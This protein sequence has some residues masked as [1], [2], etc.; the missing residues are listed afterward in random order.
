MLIGSSLPGTA[1]PAEETGYY[2]DIPVVVS[3]TRLA[4][5]VDDTPVAVTVIDRELIQAAGVVELADILRL[6]PGF[7]VAHTSGNLFT[8][9]AHGTGA[10]WF[11]R[12]QVLVDGQSRYHTG[13]SGLDWAN[14][15]IS[16]A[17]VER[18]EVVRGANTPTYGAN[19]IMG[20]VNIITRQPFQDRGLFLQTTVG[21]QDRID[22]V[23]RHAGNL[24]GM[25]YRLTLEHR[26]NRGFDEVDDDT[27]LNQASFRG[28]VN[29]TPRDELDI[30]L[31]YVES[32]LGLQLHFD[33]PLD[34]R[35]VQTDYQF[36]RWT[37]AAGTD[38][39]FYLQFT[40]DHYRTREDTRINL[41]QFSDWVG[42]PPSLVAFALPRL[43][44][45]PLSFNNF[46]G[47]S[48]RYELEF[49][50]FLKPLETF[51][52]IW[53][54]AYR[55]DE[56]RNDQTGRDRLSAESAR[57][58][59]NLEWRPGERWVTN[60]GAMLEHSTLSDA[61]AFSPRLGINYR[62]ADD[63]T[64]RASLTR[65]HKFPSLLEE[66]W[67]NYL[68]FPNGD[69]VVA[70]IVSNG[71]LSRETRTQ[72]ELGYLASLLGGNLTL[73]TRVY[74]QDVK[75]AVI[76]AY[77]YLCP[78]QPV[79]RTG[80][81]RVDN[82]I[83]YRVSGLEALASFRPTPQSLIRLTYAYADTHGRA[84]VTRNPLREQD[85]AVTVPRHSASLLLSHEFPGGI[86]GSATLYY[87]D[88]V[89]WFVDGRRTLEDY[90]RLDLR[91]AKRFSG[92]RHDGLIELIAQGLGDEY[93]EFA[94]R[95]R[96]EP[97]LFLRASLQLR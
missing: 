11:S 19:G 89:F 14:I 46:N 91:L 1:E 54:A 84:A 48:D 5:R 60:L 85:L 63:Q 71:D 40:R 9:T 12:V 4:Q 57:L 45:E 90:F 3:A 25:D 62:L 33:F 67:A 51:R 15:G 24:G 80:C 77:N 52:L 53:G 28:I 18:V 23:L 39:S 88:E 27:R 81:Y 10:P 26:E 82:E 79:F 93:E 2:A 47:E 59:S 76:Y 66:H 43:K 41:L 8:V 32:T 94:P 74:H 92:E 21:S 34:D 35:D 96:F 61:T 64:L 70:N 87:L 65:A 69:P 36:V 22:G 7:Q 83:D 68:R 20:T 37:H 56:M 95:N 97:R 73:D 72:A 58:S 13:F 6:V 50:H 86:Q 38:Q 78:E 29:L 55:W 17:D 42:A 16:L 31:G 30:Q 75:D 49:Q 44:N